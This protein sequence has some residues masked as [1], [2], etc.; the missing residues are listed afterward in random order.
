ML[1]VNEWLTIFSS[2]LM[3]IVANDAL[4]LRILSELPASFNAFFR[5]SCTAGFY[6][7]FDR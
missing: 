1:G 3:N 6:P 5:H 4:V 2:Y 7:L